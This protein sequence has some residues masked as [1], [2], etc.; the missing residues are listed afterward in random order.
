VRGGGSYYES[1]EQQHGKG[2]REG[3]DTWQVLVPQLGMNTITPTCKQTR[4]VAP[5]VPLLSSPASSFV[6][7]GDSSVR[8]TQIRVEDKPKKASRPLW[9][10][11]DSWAPA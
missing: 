3:I 11:K 8:M 2:G 4:E 9:G 1:R 5:G 10:L 6:A 7:W